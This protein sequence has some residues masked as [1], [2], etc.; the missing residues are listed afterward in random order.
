MVVGGGVSTLGHQGE[1]VVCSLDTADDMTLQ[2][3]KK[4]CWPEKPGSKE[5]GKHRAHLSVQSGEASTFMCLWL[6]N[7]KP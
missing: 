1:S 4:R 7:Y 6:R 2:T 5:V 3:A